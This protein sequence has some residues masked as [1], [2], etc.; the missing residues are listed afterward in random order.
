[1]FLLSIHICSCKG[2]AKDIEEQQEAALLTSLKA[3]LVPPMQHLDT[4]VSDISNMVDALVASAIPLGSVVQVRN[5]VG[6]GNKLNHIS[7]ASCTELL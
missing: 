1:V 3:L 7:Q 6:H 2:D 4:D 5:G